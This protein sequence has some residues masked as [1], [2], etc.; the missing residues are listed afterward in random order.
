MQIEFLRTA[1]L[2]L[3]RWKVSDLEPFALMNADAK[4]MECYPNVLTFEQS[5][6]MIERIESRF[7]NEGFG[8]WAVEVI[9]TGDFIGYVGLG[10][11]KFDSHFTPCV[12]IGW[13]LASSHWGKGYA[14][15]AAEEVIG[16]A[17]GRLELEELVSFTSKLNLK[18]IRVMKK[19]GMIN[20]PQDDFLHPSLED[21]HHLKP[22]VLYRLS[23]KSW[24]G[25]SLGRGTS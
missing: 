15:E 11:A 4:V 25:K 12:E 5:Q 7:D 9:A 21:G 18:S 14:P 2:L 6:S 17:F 3:R 10:P 24:S 8:L 22:H 1:R 20:E 13:R 19:I 16:D 23:K